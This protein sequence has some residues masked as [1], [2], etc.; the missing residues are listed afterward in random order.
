M[1]LWVLLAQGSCKVR[2]PVAIARND[3]SSCLQTHCSAQLQGWR[4]ENYFSSEHHAL[5]LTHLINIYG[6][7]ACKVDS[8]FNILTKYV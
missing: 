2:F 3:I 5:T 1:A 7:F 8:S 4:L 6:K